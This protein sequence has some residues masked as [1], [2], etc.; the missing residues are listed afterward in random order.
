M[1]PY[2]EYI[3]VTSYN[4]TWP[5]H[6]IPRHWLDSGLRRDPRLIVSSCLRV[7]TEGS[8]DQ[9]GLMIRGGKAEEVEV[10]CLMYLQLVDS[11]TLRDY[12]RQFLTMLVIVSE[13]TT[14]SL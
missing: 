9:G 13:Q 10:M 8:W 5:R 4:E 12:L 11:Y 14:A 7:Y 3:L 6:F 1:F 2:T